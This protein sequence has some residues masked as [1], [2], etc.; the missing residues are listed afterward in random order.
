MTEHGRVAGRATWCALGG[1]LAA[2]VVWVGCGTAPR[3][4]MLT[5]KRYQARPA[6]YPIELYES[7][8]QTPHEQIAIVDSI[9]VE[10]LT[11]ETRTVLVE[12]LRARARDVG[13]DAVIEVVM[14]IRPERGWVPDP[15]TPFRSWRQGWRDLHFLRGRAI[16]FKPLLIETGEA[17]GARFDFGEGE[18]PV[19]Q[20][21]LKPELEIR[22]V[23]DRYGRRGYVTRPVRPAKP[24]LPVIEMGR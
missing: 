9:G 19:V 23:T 8:V 10:Q 24:K 5:D 6:S 17:G 14:L 4:Q 20:S 2:V 12:S 18:R 11:T 22:K 21:E 1:L 13:A 7:G 16:R 3:T 15:Q